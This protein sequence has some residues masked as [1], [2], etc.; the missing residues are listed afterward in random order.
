MSDTTNL[1][2]IPLG[3][4]HDSIPIGGAVPQG[5]VPPRMPH[6]AS[7]TDNV[8][9]SVDPVVMQKVVA[10]LEGAAGRQG[11]GG[12]PIPQRNIPSETHMRSLVQDATAK[13]SAIPPSEPYALPPKPLSTSVQAS[14]NSGLVETFTRA[15]DQGRDYI[16]ASMLFL[17]FQLPF[18]RDKIRCH[19]PFSYMDDGNPSTSTLLFHS[20]MFG[21]AFAIAVHGQE[22]LFDFIQ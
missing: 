22:Y 6:A 8:S 9:L 11:S 14:S 16:I 18:V 10:D 17:L 7:P 1:S 5:T 15:V 13:P 21:I 4:T 19:T 2:D 20:A 12:V 3:P